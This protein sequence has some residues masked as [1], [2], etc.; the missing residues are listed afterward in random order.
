MPTSGKLAP[1]FAEGLTVRVDGTDVP[2]PCATYWTSSLPTEQGGF[3][4]RMDVDFAG[5]ITAQPQW[6][7]RGR[8]EFTNRTMPAAWDGTKSSCKPASGVQIFDTNAYSTS[9]TGGLSEALQ[10]VPAAGPLDERT[11]HLS[12]GDSA[13]LDAKPLS[14][15]PGSGAQESHRPRRHRAGRRSSKS[16]SEWIAHR[17]RQLVDAI[18]EPHVQ[19]RVAVLASWRHFY[20]ARCM[21]CRPV[22][23]RP[24]SA[25]I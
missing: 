16:E 3:S 19:P 1:G 2:L 22:M 7:P 5:D 18:A 8:C 4:L 9:L 11:V 14:G 10:S 15:R 25:P 12:F 20:W 21:R 23:A 6:S 24:S 13:P 17:T